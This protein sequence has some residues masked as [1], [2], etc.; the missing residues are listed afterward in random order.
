SLGVM[1]E[2][3]RE[4]LVRCPAVSNYAAWHLAM[5]HGLAERNDWMPV[6]VSQLMYNLLA[7]RIEDDY[8]EAVGELGIANVVYNPLA[9]GLLTG[10]HRTDAPPA[11]DTR[12][13][14][15]R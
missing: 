2:F 3:V 4:G 5:M 10:K 9:G 6:R 11:Q 8:L 12:F 15:R 7:R 1:D 13:S 14:L